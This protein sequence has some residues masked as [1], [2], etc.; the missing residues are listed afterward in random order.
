M[1]GNIPPVPASNDKL[2]VPGEGG[3]GTGNYNIKWLLTTIL[4]IWP[5]LLGSIIISLIIGNLY[6]RYATPYFRSSAELLIIDSKKSSSSGD[7]ISKVLGLN[8]S[9]LNIDNEIEVLR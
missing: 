6:L 8:N 9:N 2:P 4:A 3:G 5:W 7:D 1:E